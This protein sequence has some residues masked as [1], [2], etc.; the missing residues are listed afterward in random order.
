VKS[1]SRKIHITDFVS[2]V[3]SGKLDAQPPDVTV[4][5]SRRIASFK[6]C[7]QAFMSKGLDH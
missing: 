4:L 3:K 2:R 7:A 5:H 1:K 6:E